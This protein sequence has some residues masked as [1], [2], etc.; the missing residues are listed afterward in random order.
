M[1]DVQNYFLFI[2][3]FL[4][5]PTINLVSLFTLQSGNVHEYLSAK[6]LIVLH[7]T[8]CPYSPHKVGLRNAIA[9]HIP[10]NKCNS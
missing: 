5:K 2:N 8:F 6:T 10:S 1:K 9:T 7:R 3:P 4:M